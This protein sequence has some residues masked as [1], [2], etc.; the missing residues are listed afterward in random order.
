M[1]DR[2]AFFAAIRQR[3]FNGRITA[4]Q[5]QGCEAILDACISMGVTD[6]RHVSNI[7]AQVHHETGGQMVPVKETV[8]ASSAN[9][10]PS[11]AEV[12]RRLDTAFAKGH[13]PW[14]KTPYWRDGWFGRGGIQLTHQANY[15]K[16]GDALGIDLV[17]NR[18]LALGLETSARIAVVGMSRGLFTGKKLSDYFNDTKN[19]PANAR[20]IVNGDVKSVGATILE[21]HADYLAAMKAAPETSVPKQGAPLV[22]GASLAFDAILVVGLI[23]SLALFL[24]LR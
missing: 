19:D 22:F 14:V 8:Y 1:I 4:G 9:R 18:D 12:I 23:L 10:N 13:L 5:V 7:L 20:A 24:A 3:P 11:D 6:L 15:R 2:P 21:L 17:G 16:L